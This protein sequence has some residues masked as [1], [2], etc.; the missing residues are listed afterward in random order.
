[1]SLVRTKA[2]AQLGADAR[3]AKAGLV[4]EHL[5]RGDGATISD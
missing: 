5:Q 2:A 4:I 1:M 3:D